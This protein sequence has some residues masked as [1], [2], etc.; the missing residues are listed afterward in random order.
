MF[1]RR[2]R[3]RTILHILVQLVQKFAPGGASDNFKSL[4]VDYTEGWLA[5]SNL[6]IFISYNNVKFEMILKF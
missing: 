3:L 1:C 6:S 2:Y 5:F 4:R